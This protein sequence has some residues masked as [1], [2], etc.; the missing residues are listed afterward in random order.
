MEEWAIDLPILPN[1]Y[2]IVFYYIY[3]YHENFKNSVNYRCS[4][5]SVRNS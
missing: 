5:C 1:I 3:D 2:L 4:Y